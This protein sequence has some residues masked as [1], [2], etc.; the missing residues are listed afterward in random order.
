MINSQLGGTVPRCRSSSYRIEENIEFK[1]DLLD[2]DD[3]HS[4]IG[5]LICAHVATSREVRKTLV[6]DDVVFNEFH[7]LTT[8][9]LIFFLSK[10]IR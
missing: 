1:I 2:G 3:H 6:E 9:G 8:W 7:M 5:S 4:R 10:S